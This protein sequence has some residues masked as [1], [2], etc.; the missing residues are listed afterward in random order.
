MEIQ[1]LNYN[2]AF[3]RRVSSAQKPVK[4]GRKKKKKER[5]N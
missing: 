4:T 2:H 1:K 3:V 5:K